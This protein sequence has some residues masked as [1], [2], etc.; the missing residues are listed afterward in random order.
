M[1]HTL[2]LST[3]IYLFPNCVGV[4]VRSMPWAG[5][6]HADG[7]PS[8]RLHRLPAGAAHPRCG[9]PLGPL[10]AEWPRTGLS[11]PRIRPPPR[12]GAE[13]ILQLENVLPPLYHWSQ[14]GHGLPVDDMLLFFQ[15]D[16]PS[17]SIDDFA[18]HKAADF[19]IRKNLGGDQVARGFSAEAYI[20]QRGDVFSVVVSKTRMYFDFL[21][22]G[23]FDSQQE[24]V[25]LRQ[26]TF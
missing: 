20:V 4:H 5:R 15:S 7:P 22:Q 17:V 10:R 6:Q 2:S 18:S 23:F 1:C 16:Y 9:P 25:A 14:P 8:V 19:W 21:L 3:F 11:G 13:R 24:L 26:Y 12:R